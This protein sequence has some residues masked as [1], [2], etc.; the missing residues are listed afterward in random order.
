MVLGVPDGLSA[1]LVDDNGLLAGDAS[2][3]EALQPP[4]SR[5]VHRHNVAAAQAL[6]ASCHRLGYLTN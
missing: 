2:H 6:H 4:A 5:L 1:C 3:L